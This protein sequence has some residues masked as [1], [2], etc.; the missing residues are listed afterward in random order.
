M[1][2]VNRLIKLKQA[3]IV[4]GKYDKITLENIIDATII[5]TNGFRIFK[6]LEKRQL[7]RLLAK[8]CG[9][10]IITDSDSAGAVIR[11]HL[12]QICPEGSITN[13]Y[14]PQLKGKEKR[15]N[16]H[17]KEGFLGVEGMDT[18]VIINALER[19]GVLCE[20]VSKK[21]TKQITKTLL[22]ELG[23]S[24]GDNSFFLRNSLSCF[25]GLPMDISANAFLDCVNA[26]Y[27]YDE[28]IKAVE[29]WQKNKQEEVKR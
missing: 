22:F 28:F 13:V 3:V 7:I 10:I 23:L 15:K 19:S 21:Q 17:S 18:N 2:G 8:K 5:T 11:S 20:T 27:D 6:D 12:K 1:Q 24:G 9:I 25:L 29:L 4:E 14:I 26:V 16:H